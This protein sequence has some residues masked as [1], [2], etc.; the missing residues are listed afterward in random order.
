M[1]AKQ[2]TSDLFTLS[3]HPCFPS[4]KKELQ[5][6]C[7][8]MMSLYEISHSVMNIKWQ[9][10]YRFQMAIMLLFNDANDVKLYT[11]VHKNLPLAS[12]FSQMNPFH[13]IPPCT[14][15]IHFAVNQQTSRLKC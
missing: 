4:N 15:N 1:S 12:T 10:K 11:Y 3:P 2:N 5:R 7:V 14:F 8:F 13:T 6:T 9:I